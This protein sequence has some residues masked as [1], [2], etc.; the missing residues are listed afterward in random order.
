MAL[1]IMKRVTE[2]KT[3]REIT[4]FIDIVGQ[5]FGRL[6]R[7]KPQSTGG[8][9]LKRQADLN[10][11]WLGRQPLDLGMR[12]TAFW[13]LAIHLDSSHTLSPRQV[14]ND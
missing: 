10:K 14:A 6:W 3:L 12:S 4:H 11:V 9:T 7:G 1:K 2:Q 8:H 5:G 13:R